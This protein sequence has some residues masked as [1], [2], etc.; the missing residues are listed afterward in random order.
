V[1]LKRYWGQA[2]GF[3]T[4]AAVLVLFIAGAE[5]R[6]HAIAASQEALIA[7]ITLR[8]GGMGNAVERQRIVALE[9]QLSSAIEQSRA[10]KLDGDEFGGG[11]CTIYLYGPSAHRLFEIVLPIL[12]DFRP[13]AGS[14]VIKRYGG[15]GSKEDRVSLG[16]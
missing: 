14:Y 4:G 3:P 5:A 16:E 10:G 8:S 15:P 7:T 12:R 2:L 11:V 6:P 9:H 13:P 1:Q